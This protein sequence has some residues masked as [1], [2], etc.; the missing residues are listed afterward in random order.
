MSSPQTTRLDPQ[1]PETLPPPAPQ[2]YANVDRLRLLALADIV[3]YHVGQAHFLNGIGLPIFLLFTAALNARPPRDPDPFRFVKR[4]FAAFLVPWAAW[5]VVYGVVF[6]AAMVHRGSTKDAFIWFEPVMLLLGT[7][8]HLW[9]MVFGLVASLAAFFA[10]RYTARVDDRLVIML[11]SLLACAIMIPERM[12][13]DPPSRAAAWLLSLP[14]IPIGIA[15][16]RCLW[17]DD[18]HKR[19]R[20]T[21]FTF[22]LVVAGM[23]VLELQ[24]RG[25]S[26]DRYMAAMIPVCIAVLWRGAPDAI[27]TWLTKLRLG[28]YLIHPLLMRAALSVFGD[29][30]H[31]VLRTTTVLVASVAIAWLISKSPLKWMVQM[32][33]IGQQARGTPKTESSL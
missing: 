15:L 17:V 16:G 1:A 8:T 29:R 32:G 31:P 5:S 23:A 2:R 21:A 9:Y 18:L 13:A 3:Y 14:S 22:A 11:A 4:K 26:A 27:T 28:V 10:R 25:Y 12:F 24:D 30:S 6:T 33:A 20:N 7:Q 19:I